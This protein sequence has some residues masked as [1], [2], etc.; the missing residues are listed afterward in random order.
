[1]NMGMKLQSLVPAV[2]HTERSQ[3]RRRDAVDRERL[4]AEYLRWRERAGCEP[5]YSGSRTSWLSRTRMRPPPQRLR[6]NRLV[7]T[8]LREILGKMLDERFALNVRNR[9][10]A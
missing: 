8:N 10:C 1:M 9:D 2:K 5:S 6:S 3:S 4:Q 7:G